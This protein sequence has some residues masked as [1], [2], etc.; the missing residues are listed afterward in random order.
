MAA[1]M[2][3]SVD[4]SRR[5]VL[6]AD[7]PLLA[8]L[9]ALWAVNSELAG[10]LEALADPAEYS[11]ETSKSGDPT[12]ACRTADGR[13]IWLH[14]KFQPKDEAQRLLQSAGVAD[15]L[16][17]Y[18]LGFGLGYHV[19]AL[20]DAAGDEAILCIFEPDLRMLWTALNCRDYSKLISSRRLMFFWR[21]DKSEILSRLTAY[22]AV[23]SLGAKTFAH[24]PSIQLD[25]EFFRQVQAWLDELASFVRTGMNTL[26]LNSAKTAENISANIGWYAASPSVDRLKDRFR[27]SPAIVVSAGPSLR[28]NKHLLKGLEDR[29]VIIAVQTTL[30]PLLEMGVT[31]HFVTSL[32]YHEICSRF[33]EKLPADLTTELVAEP[34]ATQA[35]FQLYPGPLTIL[36]NDFAESLLRESA[37]RKT[38]LTAGSTVAHLAYYLAELMGCDPIIFVGQDLAFSDGLCYTPGTSYEEVW[39]PELS[40]YCTLEMK[41]WE[42]IVRE[43][44]ILRRV[45]DNQGNPIYTEERLFMYLQQF[46]RDF[47]K[48]TARIIDATEGGA[49]KQGAL[50]MPLAEAIEKYCAQPLPA[51]ADDCPAMNWD[52]LESCIDC[53]RQRSDEA[54]QIGRLSHQT[55][56]LLE[57]IRDHLEDQPRVNRAIARIDQI[58]AEMDKL[59]RTYDLVT[60]LTQRTELKRFERDRRVAASKA[61]G[62]DRQRLQVE[63]DIDN[64]QAVIDAAAQFEKLMSQT[65]GKLEESLKSEKGKV[66]PCLSLSPQPSVLSPRSCFA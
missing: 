60:Q 63:R 24:A 18:V 19:Q 30:Q 13:Q 17:F 41:Q 27:A 4:E 58:R 8:N 22:S 51:S 65:I 2:T 47:G 28:K 66:E 23:I 15:K 62:L 1:P 50:P 54:A 21:P 44:Q 29:A 7:A 31:P 32:D 34:K 40:R 52:V 10:E 25:P 35:V 56:P 14:S 59:G 20:A 46:E 61:T 12:L 26:V 16:F 36:G 6:P 9:A 42:Q 38:I 33:F 39:R 57:E 48:S 37:P 11:V 5:F 64:V 53:L 43:K 3:A 45:P 55:R 49:M